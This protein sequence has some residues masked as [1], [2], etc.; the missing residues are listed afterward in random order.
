MG[1]EPLGPGPPPLTQNSVALI[2]HQGS[3]DGTP[4][5][6]RP[7]NPQAYRTHR[8]YVYSACKK[9]SRVVEET[10]INLGGA[11]GKTPLHSGFRD[12]V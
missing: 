1:G 4:N 2:G 7:M 6:G 8:V 9:R 11:G 12:R 10:V 5:K 3:L